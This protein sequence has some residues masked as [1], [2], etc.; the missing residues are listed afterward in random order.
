MKAGITVQELAQRVATN[1]NSRKDYITPASAMRFRYDGSA[2]TMVMGLKGRDAEYTMTDLFTQQVGAQVGVP[3]VYYKRLLTEDP[4]LASVVINRHNRRSSA[5][6]MIRTLETGANMVA[7]A[8]LSNSYRPLDNEHFLE[9]LLPALGGIEG[10]SVTECQLTEERMYIKAITPKVQGEVKRGDTMYAGTVA[11]NS[12]VGA[13]ALSISLLA[14]RLVCLNGLILPDGKFRAFHLGKRQAGDDT[15]YELLRDET[16]AAEDR[17]L[18]MKARDVAAGIFTQENFDKV[19]GKMR[20]AA[21][22]QLETKR[23]DKAVEVLAKQVGLNGE[24][25]VSVLSHLL[26]GG[27]LSRWGFTNAL[28]RAAQDVP[29]YD[30]SVQLETLGAKVLELPAREWTALEKAA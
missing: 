2:N 16:K 1:I 7:R 27:D 13:G 17:V 25:Q 29:S 19:L 22:V 30:R 4:K 28:T 23:P 15:A 24:E 10:L 11:S 21:E 20:A 6:R 26:Q 18:L 9:Q 14:Y 3:A 12:E 8:Y 5:T